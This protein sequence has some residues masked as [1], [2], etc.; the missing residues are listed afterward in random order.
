MGILDGKTAIVTGGGSGI[1]R[2]ISFALAGEGAAVVTA[3]RTERTLAETCRT[4]EERGGRAAVSVCDI[5]VP[6]DVDACIALTVERFGGID[7]LVNNATLVPHGTLLETSEELADDTWRAGPL[8]A[9]RF[10]RKCH[11]HLCGGGSIINVSS[12]TAITPSVPNRGIYAMIKSALGAVSRAAAMEWAS[13]DIRVNTIMPFAKSDAVSRFL[14][15]EPELAMQAVAQIPLGRIGDPEQ[16]IGRAVVFLAGP[17]SAYLT[18]A[19]LPLDGGLA[20]LR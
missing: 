7:I 11:P 3:G 14:E 1:G 10:M 18:G 20:Y 19:T 13:D 5:T 8:A 6:D 4:I 15:E 17:D 9:W 2:G 16:D 12:A